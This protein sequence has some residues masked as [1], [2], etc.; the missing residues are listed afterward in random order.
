MKRIVV[1]L[2]MILF[3]LNAQVLIA[4][5]QFEVKTCK[6]VQV[7]V[8]ALGKKFGPE[9]VIVCFDVD[10]T[11]LQDNA[12]LCNDYWYSWQGHLSQTN[13]KSPS[14]KTN[15]SVISNKMLHTVRF[16]MSQHP[17]EKGTV[18]MIQQL[19]QQK[20][21]I[22]VTTARTPADY[23]ETVNALKVN[24]IKIPEFKAFLGSGSNTSV[25]Q[26]PKGELF[27][28][29][30]RPFMYANNV[31]C[32]NIQN[33]G[34][35]LL[36]LLDTKNLKNK[37]KA[38]VLVDDSKFFTDSFYKTFKNTNLDVTSLRYGYL[39]KPRQEYYKHEKKHMDQQWKELH[40]G[41][42]KCFGDKWQ[43]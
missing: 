7:K 18:A 34:A 36:Y 23:H 29:A 6:D 2:C 5:G 21:N 15:G 37:Y 32:S 24:N 4:G 17:V 8:Q 43:S 3:A 26:P 41:L 35:V 9:N 39:D 20:F 14:Y 10:S 42:N 1:G 28:Q 25:I 40:D 31:V 27:G 38:V 11:L 13:K 19:H 33:K 30:P 22:L 16:L 12:L